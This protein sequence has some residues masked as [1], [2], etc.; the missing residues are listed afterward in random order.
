MKTIDD[1][2]LTVYLVGLS[3]IT[4]HFVY[5]HEIPRHDKYW[6]NRLHRNQNFHLNQRFPQLTSRHNY[7]EDNW[8]LINDQNFNKNDQ[9]D[10]RHVYNKA[11]PT[12]VPLDR[13]EKCPVSIVNCKRNTNGRQEQKQDELDFEQNRRKNAEIISDWNYSDLK[14]TNHWKNLHKYQPD[15]IYHQ[16]NPTL[17][18]ILVVQEEENPLREEKITSS[19]RSA[20]HH[21]ER[22]KQI[23]SQNNYDPLRMEATAGS[24]HFAES[25]DYSSVRNGFIPVSGPFGNSEHYNPRSRQSYL[26]KLESQISQ[27]YVIRNYPTQSRMEKSYHKN[28]AG[29]VALGSGNFEI[30]RGGTFPEGDDFT[31]PHQQMS[32]AL[33]ERD[34]YHNPILGFQGF[35]HF[36]SP[37]Q[38]SLSNNVHVSLSPGDSGNS[39]NHFFPTSINLQAIS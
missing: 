8:K 39:P 38:G 31:Y 15:K 28:K 11:F 17:E 26:S 24:P 21:N 27:E 32:D 2:K 14:K 6:K 1:W 18:A 33:F 37:L 36:N 30:L 16:K 9:F 3:I 23:L 10:S 12:K 19:T 29:R 7:Q 22:I 13:S 20:P 5:A 4:S 25:R 34:I 35:N